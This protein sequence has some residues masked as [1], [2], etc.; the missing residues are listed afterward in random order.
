MPDTNI[1]T[2]TGERFVPEEQGNIA[3]EHLHRYLLASNLVA[4]KVVLDIASGEGYGSDLLAV[5]AKHV[6]GVDIASEAV[7]HARL[8]YKRDNLEFKDGDCANIP[9]EDSSV[10]VI[11]SF[12]TLEHH[13]QHERSFCE[14][15]RV[16]KP[17]GFLVIS[18]PDK[19][20][21]SDARN[22]NNKF[23]VKELYEDQFRQLIKQHF[24]NASFYSQRIVFGSLVLPIATSASARSYFYA[25][26]E[27]SVAQGIYEPL[28]LLAIASD[29][30]IGSLDAG[31]LEQ[32]INDTEIIR[33]WERVMAE[34]D[35]EV[36]Q[37]RIQVAADEGMLQ[38]ESE[39]KR[40][41]TQERDDVRAAL[42][43]QKAANRDLRQRSLLFEHQIE[44]VRRKLGAEAEILRNLNSELRVA[45]QR[46]VDSRS[47]KI[48][49]PLRVLNRQAHQLATLG[50]FGGRN[51]TL[52]MRVK[53]ALRY[54]IRGNLRGFVDRVRHYR[55]QALAMEVH[56]NRGRTGTLWGIM[57]TPHTVFIAH[58]IADRLAA[59]GIAS[60]ILLSPP[61]IFD[62]DFYIVLCAQMFDRLP[63]GE[64]RV[65]FQLEQT[66][67]SRWFTKEYFV[68]LENSVAVLDYSLVNIEFLEEH[69]IAYPH[70][71]YLPI[72]AS[73]KLI[74]EVDSREKEYDFVFYG[75]YFSSERRRRMLDEFGRHFKVK[76]CNGTFGEDM[77]AVIRKARGV[78]NIHYY[79]DALLEMPRIQECLSQ[80]IPVLSEE[81]RDQDDYPE[82]KGAVRFFKQNSIEDMIS[83]G[84]EFL[85]HSEQIAREVTRSV[86]FSSRRF[87]FMFDRFL[88]AIG[89]LPVHVALKEAIY[90]PAGSQIALSLPE[91]IKRRRTFLSERPDDCAIFDGIR[92][93]KGWIGCGSSYSA[94]AKHARAANEK[95]LV[96]FED[97]VLFRDDHSTRMETIESYLDSTERWDIFSGMIA[98]V[99]PQTQVLGVEV[100]NGMTFV[101]IDRMT[102][103]VFNIYNRH[104]INLLAEWDPTN[105]NVETNTVDRYLENQ[106]NLRVVVTLP[107]LVGHREDVSSTLWG[108]QNDRY[109]KMIVEAEEAIRILADRWLAEQKGLSTVEEVEV[110]IV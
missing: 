109:S 69:N 35:A 107:F 91:T 80:G 2:F 29:G 11:V 13:D 50:I 84:R 17:G 12:E 45:N 21:Y 68:A 41:L 38:K 103:M 86:E 5:H 34:R 27:I 9:L 49:A 72:G 1:M 70:V 98:S 53:N 26:N 79:E 64:K 51:P 24:Q 96:V 93:I 74:Y 57:T 56:T 7:E 18:S 76:L 66:V 110:T 25:D 87:T 99:H 90:L 6:V 60:E 100:R 108:F 3:L 22:F 47:W 39:E 4:G 77:H 94:L 46:I 15:K 16:L 106:D 67:S 54:L 40:A 102:S 48:T 61:E 71:F 23:H 10:D 95:R 63:Q 28:Y 52:Q 59:K 65:L 55:R 83:A 89:I 101:K 30:E 31:V 32:P 82:I 75:D 58:C 8:R 105:T 44:S 19:K 20:Y 78:I 62:H 33:S 85:A 43:Q 14:F 81:A 42:E 92:N 37:L 97:D 73:D 88:V 36:N 104:A